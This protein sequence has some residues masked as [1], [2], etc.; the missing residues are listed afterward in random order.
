MRPDVGTQPQFRRKKEPA[1]YRYDSS[2]SPALDWDGQNGTRELGEWLLTLV[3]QA[4]AL[5][6]PHA[7]E[8][9]QEFKA[10]D[11]RVLVSVRSLAD[12][13]SALKRL[14]RPFLNW[15]KRAHSADAIWLKSHRGFLPSRQFVLNVC[16]NA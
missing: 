3:A 8:H 13:V 7:F 1:A 10:L 5:P 15:L 14:G 9:A 11:G 4:A 12:A 16:R 6:A 2:L